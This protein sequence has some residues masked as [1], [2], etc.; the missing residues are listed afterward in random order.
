MDYEEAGD[1]LVSEL[2]KRVGWTDGGTERMRDN[3]RFGYV[4]LGQIIRHSSVL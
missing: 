1:I 4:V 2:N 3:P